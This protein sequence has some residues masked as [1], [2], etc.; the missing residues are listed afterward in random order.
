MAKEIGTTLTQLSRSVSFLMVGLGLAGIL[1]TPLAG[2]YDKR[3]V[4]IGLGITDIIG[5]SVIL[6]NPKHMPSIYAGRA[7]WGAYVSGLQYLVNSSVGDLFFVHQRGFHLAL[8]HFGFSGGNT[9]SQVIASQ[10]VQEQSYVWAFRYAVTFMSAYIFLLFL[11]IPET[12]YN[13][14]KKFDT[15]IHQV[16]ADE[17]DSDAISQDKPIQRLQHDEKAKPKAAAAVSVSDVKSSGTPEKR[18]T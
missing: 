9:L 13:R 17:L 8:W 10:I 5:Y 16:L 7:L 14:S 4:F 11:L 6:A 1:T 18:K 3:P 15:D 2:I 12:T